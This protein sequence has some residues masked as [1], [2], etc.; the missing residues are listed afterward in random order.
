MARGGVSNTGDSVG[1]ETDA[2]AGGE[3]REGEV[4]DMMVTCGF[5]LQ[6]MYARSPRLVASP[7]PSDTR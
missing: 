1:D 4:E 5:A 3:R 7:R 2:E 6:Y